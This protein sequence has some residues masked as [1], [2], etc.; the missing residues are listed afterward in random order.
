M[1]VPLLFGS[2]LMSVSAADT[3]RNDKIAM[4]LQQRQN[5]DIHELNR[6]QNDFRSL[7]QQANSRREFDLYDPDALKKDK[8]ARVHDDDP[9]CGVS[10]IQKFEGEDLNNK[11]RTKFQ[12]E[13]LREWSEQQLKEKEDAKHNQS[14]ADRLY[15]LKM[16]E[17]D[18]RA[19]DL[20]NAEDQCRKAIN[21]SVKDY[22]RSLVCHLNLLL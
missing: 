16:R 17:L 12:Q 20:Q 14:Q 11:A 22:N 19:M 4:L 10:G 9:R 3:I 7:H 21:E 2:L 15:E 5:A 13:Q 1:S 8:P 18:Q 6:A